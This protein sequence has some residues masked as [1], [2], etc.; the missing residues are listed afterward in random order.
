MLLFFHSLRFTW[1]RITNVHNQ[2]AFSFVRRRTRHPT[3]CVSL[4]SFFH[5]RFHSRTRSL[6]VSLCCFN[7]PEFEFVFVSIF[8]VLLVSHQFHRCWMCTAS[9]DSPDLKQSSSKAPTEVTTWFRRLQNVQKQF[10]LWWRRS[11]TTSSRHRIQL[12]I[13]MIITIIRSNGSSSCKHSL[14]QQRHFTSRIDT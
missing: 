13:I 9:S 11:P 3:L 12:I 5:L 8:S 4:L 10:Y 1:Y 14:V 6:L 7:F 2:A